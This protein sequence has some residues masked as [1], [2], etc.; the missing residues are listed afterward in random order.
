MSLENFKLKALL[1]KYILIYTQH[2]Y[3]KKV[4]TDKYSVILLNGFTL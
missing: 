3:I 1:A 4:K 2:N